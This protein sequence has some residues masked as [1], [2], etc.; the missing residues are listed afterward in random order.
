MLWLS[1]AVWHA[2]GWNAMDSL[3]CC[4]KFRSGRSY[5]F[6]AGVLILHDHAW[7]HEAGR[8]VDLISLPYRG[9]FLI[10]PTVLTLFQRTLI[11]P[12][13]ERNPALRM[14]RTHVG[15]V[16]W[17]HPGIW[18]SQ[19]ADQ[20]TRR[21]QSVITC[22]FRAS[23]VC[24]KINYVLLLKLSTYLNKWKLYNTIF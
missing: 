18:P 16:C 4:P 1:T 15:S 20:T 6:M 2:A 13:V 9:N 7:P 23:N 11:C 22:Q 14:F 10:S 3:S 5:W 8:I 12:K 19:P 24:K 21:Q 17:R